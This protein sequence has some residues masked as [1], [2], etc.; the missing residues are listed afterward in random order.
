M[1][2]GSAGLP[3]D[4]DNRLSY[5]QLT[6]R[7][8]LWNAEIIRLKYDTFRAENDFI[9][10][11]YLDGGGPLVRLVQI[12]L[13]TASSQLYN[14]AVKYQEP[15]RRGEISMRESVRQYLQNIQ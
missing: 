15:V 7:N 5:A 11:G 9:A 6:W 12:E 13:K 10:S 1:N 14:W 8:G 3:F 4:G 2:A